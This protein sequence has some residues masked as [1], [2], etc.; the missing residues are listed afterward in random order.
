MDSKKS[1]ES[2]LANVVVAE[3]LCPEFSTG[4]ANVA[5]TKRVMYMNIKCKIF[6]G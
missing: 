6:N 5:E 1:S 2:E 3:R 4:A